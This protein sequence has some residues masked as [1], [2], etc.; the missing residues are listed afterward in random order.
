MNFFK[1]VFDK[2][3][4]PPNNPSSENPEPAPEPEPSTLNL[5]WSF[6]SL[7]KTISTKSE[8]IIQT[9]KKDLHELRSGFNK[10]TAVIRHVASRAVHDLPASFESGAAVAQHSLESV[11]QVIDDI[12]STVWNS[13]AQIISHGKDSVFSAVDHHRDLNDD[14][15]A[16][17]STK[18][19]HLGVKYSRFDAQVR[20][21]QCD[22]DT[23]CSEPGDKEDYEKWESEGFVFEEKNEEIK[24]LISENEVVN[25]IYY[26]VVPSKV[27]D[28]SFWSRYFYRLFKLKQAEEARALLVKRAIS[29]DEEEDLSWDFDDDDD[30]EERN[31]FL[32]RGESIKESVIEKEI[33]EREDGGL[34]SLPSPNKSM[35]TLEE[36]GSNGG[37]GKD[38]DVSIVSSQ[39][40]QEED[41]GWD[42]IEYIG[43]NDESKVE[44]AENT[45]S[46]GTSR[47][48]LHNRFG[49]AEEQD[50]SWDV[51][52]EVDLPVK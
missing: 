14:S 28:Q 10:E 34:P 39:S 15:D 50:L 29:G 42:E 41:L 26:K 49:S 7:I 17:S 22:L 52:D 3:T 31:G 47:V 19:H 23:Y 1:S 30:N 37:S 11:G 27:D 20:A 21:L 16:S 33:E 38:S 51:Q 32:W 35:D 5:A 48:E 25:Q 43:S 12:G 46:A 44:A 40:L 24:R 4:T 2:D 6:D 18:R 36:K 9:Y 13:T 45:A 8:S